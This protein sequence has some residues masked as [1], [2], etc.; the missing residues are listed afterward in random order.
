MTLDKLINKEATYCF[1]FVTVQGG[2]KSGNLR[3]MDEK[4]LLETAGIDA[5]DWEKTPVSV[6][7]LVVQ[8]G[9][10]I[11]QLEEHLKELQ[12]AKEQLGEKVNRNS[13]NS[14]S[15]PASDPPNRPTRKK[16]KPTGKKRGG[17]PGHR[18]HSRPLY[19]VEECSRVMD[20]Y[21]ETCACCGERLTGFDPH[22]YR[23]QVVEIPPV[24]LDIEEHRLHQ[25]RCDH[26][27]QKT[28]AS[29]PEEVEASG[30]RDRVVAIVSLMSGMYRHSQRMVVSAMSDLFG[31]RISLGSVNRL[32]SEASEAVSIPVAEA[33]VYVQSQPIVGAD[34]TGF[35]QGNA[36]GQNPHSKKAWLWVAVTPW[37]S[38]FQVL[39]ARSTAAAQTLLGQNFRGILNSDRYSAYNWLDVAQRQ[40]CWAHLKRE[41]TKIS[42]RTGLSH[43]LGRDLLAQQKKLFRLWHRVRDGTLTRTE[44]RSLVSPIREKVRSWL[45]QGADYQIGSKEKT[46]LAKTVRTCRQ[47]LKVEPALWL[48]VTVESLEPTNNGAERAIRPAVLWRRTS[49][50]SQSE[51]GSVFV[52]RMLTVVTSLRS[53]N[54]NV[55]EF[56]TEAIRA[57]RQGT[58][59]PSLLPQP[60][61]SNESMPLA[62]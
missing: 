47:L 53:Q 36:D 4:H 41:F 3:A 58:S 24:K 17:Q 31:V 9:L 46:P 34:E 6:R 60:S 8:L 48:F 13:E 27:G 19:P 61:S 39:L 10:K 57:A 25:L 37:V 45:Q 33:Q 42:E 51:A 16:K 20:Y 29:L 15:S 28:R 50:G 43:Q 49:F 23:H 56:M 26:C 54:R 44:F 7:Q 59:P 22:P 18:G 12:V 52:A 38:F 62:A 11:E 21:P 14:H 35:R 30:Y 40:L 1:Y 32:R 55:L 5:E 2:R